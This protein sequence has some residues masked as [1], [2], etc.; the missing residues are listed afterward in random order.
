MTPMEKLLQIMA[1][2]RDPRHGC[3]W[4]L[5]QD[6][7]SIAPHTL[8]ETY[9]VIDAIESGD[10]AHLRNELGDLLF[11]VVFYAQLG[12][13]AALFDFDAIVGEISAKLLHRHPHVFP[14]GTTAS[15]GAPPSLTPAQVESNWE[16]LK[17]REREGKKAEG[18]ARME[19]LLDDVPRAFPA[20]LRSFKIQKRAASAGFDWEDAA[21]VLAK[22]K[23]ETA[24][25][26]QAVV[27][28]GQEAVAEEL[29]DLLFTAVNLSRHLR[30]DPETA[31]R[32]ANA[33]FE[34]RFRRLEERVREA[35]RSLHELDLAELEAHWQAVKA[36]EPPR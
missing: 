23:E 29:G 7:R 10:H 25:L 31:L 20:L 35:G 14:D 24:E 6:F 32:R 16:A 8:E 22:L 21:G 33:K 36:E 18:A 15:F 2:L 13:E 26:E 27:N 11:Q 30:Q 3:P 9:E 34:K 1:M 19:S 12:K 5:R 4:D 28:E 17:Q